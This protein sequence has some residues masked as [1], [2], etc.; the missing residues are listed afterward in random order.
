MEFDMISLKSVHSLLI[1][2]TTTVRRYQK[3]KVCT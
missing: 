3:N 2:V 1:L